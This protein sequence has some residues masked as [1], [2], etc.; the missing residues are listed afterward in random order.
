MLKE[1]GK[2]VTLA[3]NLETPENE[4]IDRIAC[5]RVCTNQDCKT[6]YNT[7]LNPPKI[8]GVCDRCGSDLKQRKDDNVE[9]VRKRLVTYYEQSAPIVDYYKN[10]GVL[11]SS[12]VS[13]RVNKMAVDV[14]NE[15]YD[16]LTK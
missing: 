7:K 14:A 10:K 15:V 13:L 6:V 3:V 5:R 8:D 12:E 16:I 4:I 2:S 9:T 11:Y 1:E